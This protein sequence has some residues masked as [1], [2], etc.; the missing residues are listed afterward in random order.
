MDDKE[1]VIEFQ[2][3]RNNENSFVIK[4]LALLELSNGVV[5]YFIFKPPFPLRSLLLNQYRT[6]K[7]LTKSF[8]HISWEEGSI[9]YT[10]LENI[11]VHY[12]N[13][14]KKIYTSGDEK[15]RFI[16]KF[17]NYPVISCYMPKQIDLNKHKIC[18]VQNE[19]H[20]DSKNCA[21]FR[22]Y[23]LASTLSSKLE[24]N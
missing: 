7:W 4:E 18:G 9:D 21:L 17:T 13:Q 3:F 15:R 24:Q 23:C 22:A 19:K 20:K 14:F 6:N 11:M 16:Q 1:C 10:E 5:R 8:H 2:A 12:C